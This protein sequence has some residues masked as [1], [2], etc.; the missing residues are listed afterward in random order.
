MTVETYVKSKKIPL[1]V[2]RFYYLDYI[3]VFAIITVIGL[4]CICDYYVDP[5]NYDKQLWYVL[6]YGNEFFR[7]GVPL[8]FMISGFLLLKNPIPDAKSF[9]KRR[10]SKIL[11]PFIFYDIFY[12]LFFTRLYGYQ[13]SLSRFFKELIGIG[14]AYHLWFIFSIAFIYLMIPFLKIIVD[15]C[16]EKMLFFAFI[17]I[18][19]QST[20]KPFINLFL[21]TEPLNNSFLHLTEDGMIG[22]VGYVLLGYILGKTDFS[23]KAT[24]F[25]C[26][27]GAGFF[28]ITPIISTYCVTHGGEF[29]MHGGYSLN[30]YVESAAVFLVFK[31]LCNKPCK[32]IFA[33]SSVSFGA[34]FIHVFVLEI[35]K[36][37]IHG[38]TPSVLMGLMFII[39]VPLSFLWGFA[40][41]GITNLFKKRKKA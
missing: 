18:T 13:F 8:F 6:S 33:L 41:K 22:Y 21:Q 16:S 32:L 30:H 24:A 14:S 9:Y 28:L 4:H 19:F 40:E 29:I 1:S 12:F 26:V 35:A 10:L 38:V 25:I 37:T 27:A 15:K 39:A 5:A 20:I 23:K 3:R 34:Y 2:N 31:A 7:M 17:L 11:I 36:L